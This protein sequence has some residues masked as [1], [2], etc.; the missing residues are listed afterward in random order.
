MKGK[1][2][3]D[4]TYKILYL[5]MPPYYSRK[6][7][8][9]YDNID[10]P[11]SPYI[12]ISN[13]L[14]NPDPFLVGSSF[15][16]SMYFV[17][18][19]HLFRLGFVGKII[20]FLISPIVRQKSTQETQTVITMFRR[21]KEKCNICIFAEGTTSFNGKT[22]EIQPAIGKL[23]K[24]SG[25][26]LVTYRL[27]GAYFT[28][29]RWSRFTHKGKMTG[30]C[31]NIYSPEQLSTMSTEEI[32]QAIKNDLYVD[33]YAD[34]KNNPVAYYGKRPAECLETILY[35]CPVCKQFTTL[36]SSDDRL[37]CSCG[38]TVRYN[39]YAYFEFP[40][41]SEKPPFTTITDWSEWQREE[42]KEIALSM[43][44]RDSNDPV[45]ADIDQ[46]LYSVERARQSK[47]LIRGKLCFFNNRISVIDDAEK[48][49][50]FPLESII[51]IEFITMM[52][53]IFSTK[54]HRVYEIRS[55]YPRSAL[56]YC[57]LFKAWQSV[58]K[59]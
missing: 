33:A 24:R 43:K 19:D 35:L 58:I 5:I 47:E 27:S 15:K 7:N 28:R 4:L 22:G 36:K 59:E 29:P 45:F 54:E 23:V 39:E 21:L 9:E 41:S 31:V 53:I 55:N 10:V 51:E 57:E 13:H 37:F 3:H 32:F 12:V 2:R 14:T 34:Q 48:A 25:V 56:K 30:K 42:V 52:T 1:K 11:Y 26:A 44:S 8:F 17:A 46:T 38:F 50:E 6:F 20:E 18:S 49:V 40:G 16:K